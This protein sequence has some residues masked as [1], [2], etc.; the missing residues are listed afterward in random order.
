MR[1]STCSTPACPGG[2]PSPSSASSSVRRCPSASSRSDQPQLARN[3]ALAVARDFLQRLLE[4]HAGRRR[5]RQHVQDRRQLHQ[6][7]PV[8]A[9]R[10]AAADRQSGSRKPKPNATS[11]THTGHGPNGCEVQQVHQRKQS[12]RR[13][14][15]PSTF[16][17]KNWTASTPGP[18]DPQAR[19]ELARPPARPS[20]TS[21]ARSSA[22][23]VVDDRPQHAFE[24][25]RGEQRRR[26]AARGRA[27]M[28][29]RSSTSSSAAARPGPAS[30][31]RS[32]GRSA[33]GTAPRP[34]SSGQTT[35]RASS[36]ASW[37]A[38]EHERVS[39]DQ[40]P[41]AGRAGGSDT[42]WPRSRARC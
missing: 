18:R 33:P 36:A 2:R 6:H 29:I 12:P 7:Q 23:G 41:R 10:R 32:A 5:Q 20:R 42:A 16:S 26:R 14:V 38:A 11:H 15:R 4:R 19:L 34:S 30:A 3:D 8:G 22:A 17:P 24:Q 40:H 39:S 37:S 25:P 28:R 31:G 21:S 27:A 9:A 35:T 13:S 1:P